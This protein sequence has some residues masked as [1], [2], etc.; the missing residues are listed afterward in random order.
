MADLPHRH[1]LCGWSVASAIALP[2]LPSRDGD[3][4][5]EI[6]VLLGEVPPLRCIA[7]E[8]PV[9][10]LNAA[11]EVR[12]SIPG[13]A[14]YRVEG[15]ARITIAPHADADTAAVRLFLFGSVFALLCHQRGI[16]PLSGTTVEVSGRAIVLAGVGASGRSTLGA[17]FLRRGHRIVADDLTPVTLHDSE[18]LALPGVPRIGLWP[19]AI[20]GL[21]WTD[22]PGVA[23]REG[24]SKRGLAPPD[25]F[26]GTRV[27]IAAVVH[28]ERHVGS[29]G[30]AIFRRLRGQAAITAL[31]RRVLRHRSLHALA[32][33]KIGLA[34]CVA[35]AGRVPRHFTLTRPLRYDDLDATVDMIVETIEAS[36]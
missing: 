14:D 34:R 20:A 6:S 25:A 2:E 26:A 13:I 3:G 9:A 29:I 11:G 17:A 27:P 36:Q 5:A 35:L 1:R 10:Q 33:N 28:L 19:D 32:G 18:A 30:N 7:L 8:T 16:V 15:G 31:H 12:Y 4:A 24:I 22:Q 23:L 21:G